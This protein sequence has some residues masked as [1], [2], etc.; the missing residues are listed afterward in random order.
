MQAD[1]VPR[2]PGTFSHL[3][4]D[5]IAA[6]SAGRGPTRI[7]EP[8]E[9]SRES[10]SNPARRNLGVGGRH[11]HIFAVLLLCLP[12]GMLTQAW[13][14][15]AGFR[16]MRKRWTPRS[17]VP[18]GM[19][20]RWAGHARRRSYGRP[21][22]A[23]PRLA[24]GDTTFVQRCLAP[25]PTLTSLS[26]MLNSIASFPFLGI[27]SE[28]FVPRCRCIVWASVSRVRRSVLRTALDAG[29]RGRTKGWRAARNPLKSS[30]TWTTVRS[31][32]SATRPL[33]SRQMARKSRR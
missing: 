28:R 26:A 17:P 30:G 2:C 7:A 10:T 13:N 1:C 11:R 21:P 15:A 19:Y 22:W 14:V 16:R 24:P 12:Q 6:L 33:S 18:R 8:V 3:A 9:R 32:N 25:L 5:L 31:S 4:E 29:A 20:G 23:G 27:C